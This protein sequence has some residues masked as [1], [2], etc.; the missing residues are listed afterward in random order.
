MLHVLRSIEDRE[1]ALLLTTPVS[2]S[3]QYDPSKSGDTFHPWQIDS[4]QK[5]FKKRCQILS[6][7]QEAENNESERGDN[8]SVPL[9][10]PEVW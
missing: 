9:Q 1:Q 6:T 7:V 10:E 3:F 4:P 2:T 8:L 5:N